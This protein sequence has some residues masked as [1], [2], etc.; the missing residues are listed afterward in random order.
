MHSLDPHKLGTFVYGHAVQLDGIFSPDAAHIPDKIFD[1]DDAL[2]VVLEGKMPPPEGAATEP[3]VGS[4][5]IDP[6][7]PA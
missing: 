1:P 2:T 6:I 5:P 4:R 3:V 7:V